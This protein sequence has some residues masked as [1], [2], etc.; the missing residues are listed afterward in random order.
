MTDRLERI[1]KSLKISVSD[2]AL[3]STV[4][5]LQDR[6]NLERVVAMPD[7]RLQAAEL[8]ELHKAGK[9]KREELSELLLELLEL[10]A[11][12]DTDWTAEA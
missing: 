3:F 1:A 2:F 7:L 11:P 10:V 9:L 6:E 4:K 5:C 8:V 12:G